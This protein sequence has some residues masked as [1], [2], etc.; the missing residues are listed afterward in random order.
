MNEVLRKLKTMNAEKICENENLCKSGEN[1][2]KFN[3]SGIYS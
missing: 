3:I 2:G 1:F